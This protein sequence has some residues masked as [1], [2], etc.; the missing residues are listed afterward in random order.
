MTVPW[1]SEEKTHLMNGHS[2]ISAGTS[3]ASETES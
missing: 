2:W 1:L 3:R